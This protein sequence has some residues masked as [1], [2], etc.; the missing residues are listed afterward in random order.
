M[1]QPLDPPSG[2]PG[3]PPPTSSGPQGNPW[4][5]RSELGFGN[6]FLESLKE[7]ITNPRGTFEV[8]RPS[9]DLGG[10]LLFGI[11]VG[12]IGLAVSQ[13]WN[14]LMG[15]GMLSMMPP[16][17][18]DQMALW[19]GASAGGFIIQ[20]L[21]APIWIII[22]LFISAAIFHVMLLILGATDQSDA[23]FVGTFRAVSFASVSNLAQIIPMVGGL[24]SLVWMII[25]LVMGFSSL[26]RTS[27]GKALAAVLIPA[28]L[29]CAAIVL[30]VIVAAGSIAA[31]M[32]Q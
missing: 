18:R 31:F 7:L 21:L 9:G 28:L 8:T 24:I 4:D 23:G 25:L 13:L 29:C 15:S 11:L 32:N 17:M 10:A 5:R 30:G 3:T 2:P 22:G 12:W 1:T 26:H 27:Q 16:E 14:L 6:A 20:V 19:M